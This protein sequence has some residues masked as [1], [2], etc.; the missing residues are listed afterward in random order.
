MTFRR[1]FAPA[2]KYFVRVELRD[3]GALGGKTRIFNYQQWCQHRNTCITWTACH[4]LSAP[5]CSRVSFFHSRNRFNRHIFS[6]KFRR[7]LLKI[8]KRCV[9]R[10]LLQECATLMWALNEKEFTGFEGTK[11]I[12]SASAWSGTCFSDVE[13]EREPKIRLKGQSSGTI[14]RAINE[15]RIWMAFCL[16]IKESTLQRNNQ[17]HA[18]M[19][20]L[21]WGV[22]IYSEWCVNTFS[23]QRWS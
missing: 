21:G 6:V 17:Q 22:E 16:T 5:S 11:W 13:K 9:R 2:G 10:I 3:E 19:F 23:G 7:R 12:T 4:Y 20:V 15:Q 1:A 8:C 14:C 18:D